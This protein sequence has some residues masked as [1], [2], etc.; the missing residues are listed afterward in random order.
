MCI[1]VRGILTLGASGACRTCEDSEDSPEVSFR[2]TLGG[3]GGGMGGGILC[4]FGTFTWGEIGIGPKSLLAIVV[5]RIIP[6][7]AVA[8]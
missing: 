3:R 2:L 5:L 6:S 1:L 4:A 8:E 7:A